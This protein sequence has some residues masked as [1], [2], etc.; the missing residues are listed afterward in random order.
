MNKRFV[1]ESFQEFLDF[2]NDNI[3]EAKIKFGSFAEVQTYLSSNGLDEAGLSAISN[4][5]ELSSKASDKLL[6]DRVLSNLGSA[7]GKLN[8]GDE[9]EI[10][11]IVVDVK[12]VD[13]SNLVGGAA[14][15]DKSM[16]G[17]LDVDKV[18]G[19]VDL[20]NLLSLINKQNFQYKSVNWDK[21]DKQFTP[22]K[23]EKGRITGDIIRDTGAVDQWCLVATK[24]ALDF[25]KYRDDEPV[26][27][28]AAKPEGVQVEPINFREAK[29]EKKAG[30]WSGTYILY[31]PTSIEPGKGSPYKSTELIEVV[32]PVARKVETLKPIIIQNDDVLF[33]VDKSVLK[34]E[35]KAA[36]LNALSNVAA[37]KTIKVTGGASIEGTRER[38]EE[39]CKERAQAVADFLKGG[40]FK[41]AEVT[42]SD[43]ADIQESGEIDPKRRRVILD[44]TGERLVTSTKTETETEFS[45]QELTSKADKV[46]IRQVAINIISKFV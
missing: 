16:P 36:I 21:E 30:E 33:D 19:R 15:T 23:D 11:S 12:D 39:L 2:T 27:N 26:N 43:K 17:Y 22:T 8:S 34:E 5:Q 38:N 4:A 18:A 37:A 3:N 10:T 32:R 13:Y 31:Y 6:F 25:K 29:K 44:I 14:I 45:A 35:G 42:I 41:N 7:L 1:F 9:T 20:P 46:T 24:G 40:A 28:W